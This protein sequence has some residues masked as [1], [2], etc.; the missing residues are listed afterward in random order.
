MI[1]SMIGLWMGSEWKY[2][3]DDT[4]PCETVNFMTTLILVTVILT[5]RFTPISISTE[6]HSILLYN[7]ISLSA[8][9]FD[10]AEYS[11]NEAITNIYG[12]N[13]IWCNS[14]YYFENSFK[15]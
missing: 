2:K 12:V 11:N 4:G 10:F 13:M 15:L 7:I 9:I 1:T 6:E 5:R 14:F 8:D 3:L